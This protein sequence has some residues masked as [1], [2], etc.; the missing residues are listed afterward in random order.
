MLKIGLTG[1]IG[2][3]KT[4]VSNLFAEYGIPI[5]DADIISH[6][7]V[8]PGRTGT[9]S[10]SRNLWPAVINPDGSLDRKQLAALVFIGLRTIKQKLEAIIHPL[11]F[12]RIQVRSPHSIR[13]IALS[14]F[15]Y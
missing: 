2:S 15:P 3:G 9:R 7:L 14:V 10:N 4:T 6:Q 11:V 1:G 13:L 5:I 8:E 12:Q